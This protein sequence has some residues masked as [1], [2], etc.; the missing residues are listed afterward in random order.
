VVAPQDVIRIA[1]DFL[2]FKICSLAGTHPKSKTTMVLVEATVLRGDYSV[3]E[4]GRDWLSGM[5]L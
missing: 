4:I 2:I 3:L 5:N 1:P